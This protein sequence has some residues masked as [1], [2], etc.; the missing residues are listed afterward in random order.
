MLCT[1]TVSCS[2]KVHPTPFIQAFYNWNYSSCSG[3]YIFTIT[4]LP[5][6]KWILLHDLNMRMHNYVTDRQLS[7]ARIIVHAS[8]HT[9]ATPMLGD[10]PSYDFC[11]YNIMN[12]LLQY[13]QVEYSQL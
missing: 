10:R 9:F 1:L 6:E 12:Y 13:Q 11:Y 5:C 3:S 7:W 4:S 2:E 8:L